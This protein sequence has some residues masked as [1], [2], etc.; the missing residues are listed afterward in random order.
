MQGKRKDKTIKFSVTY[1][2]SFIRK[3]LHIFLLVFILGIGFFFRTYQLKERMNYAHDGDLYSWIVKDIVVN[4]HFRLIGQLTSADGI[5]IGPGFYYAI[6]P[7]MVLVKMDPFGAAF[8][9]T[10]VGALSIFSYYLVFSRL[11]N[12]EIGLISSFLQAVLIAPIYFD[13]RVVPST[14]T[15]LWVVWFFYTIVMLSRGNYSVLPLL[16]LLLA[17]VWH[18]HIALLP[19]L[20]AIPMAVIFS[21]KLPTKK[22]MIQFLIL[23]IIF[24]LPLLIFE[25]RHQFIQTKSLI[26]NF[27]VNHGGDSGLRKWDHVYQMVSGN[28]ENLFFYPQKFPFDNRQL[29][30]IIILICPMLLVWKRVVRPIELLSLYTLVA[31]VLLFFTASSSTISEYYFNSIEIVEILIVSGIAYLVYKWSLLGKLFVLTLAAVVFIK[32]FTFFMNEKI[33]HKGYVE[34]KSAAEFIT[35]DARSKDFPCVAVSYITSPGEDVGFRYFF[36]LNRL[37]VNQP[38]NGGPVYTIVIPDEL[39]NGEGKKIFG[40]IGVIPPKEIPTKDQILQSCSGTDPNLTDPM[41]GYTG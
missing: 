38:K 33:Y 35:N 1:I 21:R 34:R 18:I 26:N 36:W 28:A 15:N 23:T 16:A 20:I 11:F 10:I 24:S 8:F 32:N 19:T 14:P 27:T 31:G 17:A 22:Q 9:V 39:A 7:F 4:R 40:H 37:H 3:N 2:W 12:K 5:F 25:V 6:I 30:L 13:R 41:F 29:F